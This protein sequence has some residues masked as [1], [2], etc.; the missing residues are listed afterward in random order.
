MDSPE[1]QAQGTDQD[2]T[3][4]THH[5]TDDDL[6]VRSRHTA[7]AGA[8]VAVKRGRSNGGGSGGHYIGDGGSIAGRVGGGGLHDRGLGGSGALRSGAIASSTR[9]GGGISGGSG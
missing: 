2:G 3:A 1:D 5:D 6:L 9:R 7:R 4:D 8:L